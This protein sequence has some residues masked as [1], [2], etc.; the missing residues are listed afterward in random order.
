MWR[1]KQLPSP[2]PIRGSDT[3]DGIFLLTALDVLVAGWGLS[4]VTFV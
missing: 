4:G 2:D 3:W 1:R